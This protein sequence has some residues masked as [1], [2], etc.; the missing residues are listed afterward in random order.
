MKFIGFEYLIEEDF[1]CEEFLNNNYQNLIQYYSKN[2]IEELNDIELIDTP[3]NDF[4]DPK[5][6]KLLHDTFIIDNHNWDMKY[7]VY[8][9]DN[10]TTKYNWHNHVHA[11]ES[12][13]GVFYTKIPKEG[14]ELQIMHPPHFKID[15]PLTFKP[16]LNKIYL[17]PSWLYHK[18]TPQKDKEK[19][20]CINIGYASH[21]RPIVKNFGYIW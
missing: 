21:S 14:G 3:I 15:E 1:E 16:Q 11:P 9:Q 20:I 12:I 8:V 17:F 6:K 2:K 18:P 19:R 5:I 10:T 13:C 4:F 7:N